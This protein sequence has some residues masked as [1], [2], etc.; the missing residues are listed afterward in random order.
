MRWTR[1][2]AGRRGGRVDGPRRPDPLGELTVAVHDGAGRG[3]PVGG[4][5][6]DHTDHDPRRGCHARSDRRPRSLL[7][8][9]APGRGPPAVGTRRRTVGARAARRS[10]AARGHGRRS[11]RRLG[12]RPPR[13]PAGGTERRTRSRCRNHQP[14]MGRGD[15]GRRPPRGVAVG[16]ARYSIDLRTGTR[17]VTTGVAQG[18][19]RCRGSRWCWPGRGWRGDASSIRVRQWSRETAHQRSTSSPC[20]SR[21]CSSSACSGCWRVSCGSPSVPVAGEGGGS[22]CN[23][24]SPCA[25]WL[26]RGRRRSRR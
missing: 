22:R 9:Q 15:G 10:R 21:C 12:A 24:C 7:A 18:A 4:L 13:R 5:E 6:H 17:A 25:G 23:R 1:C 8:R 16:H 11:N 14:C 2:P 19:V 20:C 3:D 26:R